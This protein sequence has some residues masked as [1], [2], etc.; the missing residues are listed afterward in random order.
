MPEKRRAA[1]RLP[2]LSVRLWAAALFFLLLAALPALA[3]D[4]SVR[5]AAD[6]LASP[7]PGLVVVDVRTPAEFREGHLPGAVNMDF[8]G[9]LFEAQVASLPKD[10]TILLYCRT[11]NRSAGAEES[12]KAAGLTRILH[13][14]A[15]TVGW[16]GAGL[17]VEK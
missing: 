1:R 3:V 11:G 13:M 2:Y 4:V 8:F 12:M 5:E 16:R 10:A 9:G 7:P 6:L 15:G 14:K 17:P